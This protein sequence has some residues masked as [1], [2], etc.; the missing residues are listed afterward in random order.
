MARKKLKKI[1]W[2]DI[3][4]KKEENFKEYLTSASY[5]MGDFI[6]HQ[7]FG[8]GYIQLTL[9]NKIEVLFEDKVRLLVHNI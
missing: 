7:S 2:T 3:L 6:T 4:K 5:N 1:T 8:H 9:G